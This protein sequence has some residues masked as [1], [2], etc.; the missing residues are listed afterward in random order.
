[1][2]INEEDPEHL[3]PPPESHLKL[4]VEQI[5]LIGRWI[6]EGA[7][8]E[9][10]WAYQTPQMTPLPKVE[11]HSWPT[12]D[13]DR[14]VLAGLEAKGIEPAPEAAPNAWLRR[15]T[16]DLTGLPPTLSEIEAFASDDSPEA[17]ERVVHRLR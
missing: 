2:L 7:K 9:K 17:K 11:N 8:Y 4:T 10:H 14:F 13:V 5:E 1:L 12:T 6:E 15:V 3:M 16:Q